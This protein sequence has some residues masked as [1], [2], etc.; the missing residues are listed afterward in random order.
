MC[1]WLQCH[2]IEYPLHM[3]MGENKKDSSQKLLHISR[4]KDAPYKSH[5]N[6]QPTTNWLF[7]YEYPV[8]R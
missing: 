5:N 2:A 4:N 3:T 8:E 7:I 6:Q 1:Q